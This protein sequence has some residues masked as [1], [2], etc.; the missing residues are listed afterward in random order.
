M[1][2]HTMKLF[3]LLLA[4][5][6]VVGMFAACNKNEG[7]TDTKPENTQGTADQGGN[8][9]SDVKCTDLGTPLADVR[10]RKALAYAIDMD[11]IIDSLFHGKAQKAISFTSPGEWLN[12]DIDT[13]EYNPEKA[14][15]LLAEAGWPADY[16]LDVVYYYDDQQTVDLMTIIGQ[17]W[18]EVGVKAQF[19]KLE[20]DLAAQL[21]VA[22]AN[23]ATD[24]SAVAWDLAYAAVAAL[25]ESEFYTRYASTATNN[26]HTPPVEGMDELIAGAA[27]TMNTDEQKQ[28]FGEIQKKL[29]SD[30]L[31]MPLYHQV[32]FVYTSDHIKTGNCVHGNDQFSYEKDILNWTTDRTD[33]TLYTNGGP[34]EFFFDPTINPGQYLY[35][36]LVFDR[37]LNADYSLTPTDGMIAEK[38]TLSEDNLS[39]EFTL[40]DGLTWH[41]GKALT[42]EDVRFTY[43]LYMKTPGANSV[44]TN[45][46]NA[47]VG[48]EE[49]KNG[50]AEHCEG[51]VVD[52]NKVT[53]KFKSVA[54]DALL[55]FSQWPILPQHCLENAD[56]TT[57]QQN[58]FWQKPI[59][60]G[61][62]KIGDV[63]MNNYCTLERY[64]GYW[65]TGN[66]N[67][68]KIYMTASAETDSN[69]VLNT[70]A[71]KI[72]YAWS[73]STDDCIAIED[74]KNMTVNDAN[75]RY[76][77]CFFINKFPHKANI[78]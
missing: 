26:S 17:F 16:T 20:G 6:M 65:K 10:V 2:K 13:Y 27:A 24:D 75:I 63:V 7:N 44:M 4:L 49:F 54:A 72:D 64:D 61:P 39:V 37:L 32:C 56:P 12:A 25:S 73:K 31:A 70:G 28:I 59:G 5:T 38:Y 19:R 58:A 22:P 62:Y 42:A 11:S 3:A 14:K 8:A 29:A 78:K 33:K 21:W 48:A 66:G 57:L 43:E 9:G 46:L 55:V 34:L 77:R 71:G 45:V 18:S 53:F 67:I 69:L 52:G 35:Q 15:A 1:K 51:I 76:T 30:V 68:E 50:T 40:R 23:P 60:S 36:E 74:M 41:D 47:L